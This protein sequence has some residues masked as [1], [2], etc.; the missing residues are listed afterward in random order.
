MCHVGLIGMD[1]DFYHAT[2]NGTQLK[3]YELVISKNF[4]LIFSDLSWLRE[5]ETP[6]SDTVDEQGLQCSEV[7]RSLSQSVLTAAYQDKIFS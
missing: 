3:T 7:L 4:H 5:T 1:R 6:E 2:Q